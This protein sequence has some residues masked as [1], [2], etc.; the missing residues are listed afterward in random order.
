MSFKKRS[1]ASFKHYS[2]LV[3]KNHPSERV[4][5]PLR[6]FD[7]EYQILEEIIRITDLPNRSRVLDIGSGCGILAEGIIRNSIKFNQELTL[8]DIT[9]VMVKLDQVL[10][11][12]LKNHYR[13]VDGYFPGDFFNSSET[14]DLIIAY[15]VLQ[16]VDN[17][18]KFILAAVNLLN[19]GGVLFIGDIPNSDKRMRYEKL[20][21]TRGHF[22]FRFFNSRNLRK[23]FHTFNDRNLLKLVLMLR[24]INLEANIVPQ[25]ITLP[26]SGSREDLI[27]CFGKG[28]NK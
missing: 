22:R 12:E 8:I 16:Y 13:R 6:A 26:H 28:V 17:P 23:F 19:P 2:L 1:K 18:K 15:S 10:P 4:G 9:P 20:S 24:R 25:K 21:P 5:R 27:V 14:F 3:E 11:T 7:S